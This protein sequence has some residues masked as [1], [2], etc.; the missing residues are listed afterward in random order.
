M[1]IKNLLIAIALI[2]TLLGCSNPSGF[3]VS[4]LKTESR[5]NPLGIDIKTPRLSWIIES[6]K[7]GEK[8]TAYHILVASSKQKL[9]ENIGDLWDTQKV[10]DENSTSV[11]YEGEKLESGTE[12]FWKVKVWNSDDRDSE[13]SHIAK[14]SMGLLNESDWKAEWIGLDKAVGNDNPEQEHRVL[15]ARYLRKEFKTVKPVKRAMAYIV[16]LGVYEMYLNG[17]KVGDHVLSPGLTEFLKRSLYVTYDISDMIRLGENT[18]G[19]ILGNGRFFAPRITKP[20]NTV[21]YGYPKMLAHISLEYEDGSTEI[22]VSDI[23]WKITTNGPI[24]ENNEYDG[25]YYDARKEMPGWSKNGFDDLAWEQAEIVEK[26]SKVI[27]SQMNEPIRV[28]ETIKPVAIF[29]P[30]NGVYIFDMGQNMVGWTKLNVKGGKGTVVKQRFA[31][32]LK[33]DSTL[34]MENLRS[35]QATDTYILKGENNEIFEPRF[36]IHGFRYVELTGYP[37]VPNLST[38][39]GKVV[40]D[41][42]ELVGSFE[43]SNEL[44]NKIYKNAYWGIRGNYR[45]IPVD[46]PQRDERQGWLGDRSAGSKGESYMFDVRNFYKK[47]LVDIFDSQKANGSIP[48]VSPVYWSFYG[49]N[50]TWAG[51]P[52]QIVKMLYD[53]YGDIDAVRNRY[54]P[55]KRWVDYMIKN[56]LEQ[57][58]MPR[59]QYGDWCVPPIDPYRNTLVDNPAR[60]TPGEYIGSVYF[61]HNLRLMQYYAT[62]LNNQSDVKYFGNLADRMKKAINKKFFNPATK[63]YSNNSPT[64]NIL[65][66]AFDLV[67]PE[68]EREVFNNLIKKIEIDNNSH[69]STG[70]IGQQ[71]V[72]QVLTKYGR[73]DLAYTINTKTDFPSFGYMIENGATTIWELWNSNLIGPAM[74]SRNHVMMLGDFITW[75][76]EDLAGIK[77][78]VETTSFKHLIM[79]P[80]LIDGLSFVKASYK[81]V[82]GNI[83]S[84]WKVTNNE[85]EWNLCIPVNTTATIFIPAK[86]K[87]VI[88]ED[89]KVFNY[90][91]SSNENGIIKVDLSAGM[92]HVLSRL[93]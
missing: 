9:K 38:I 83:K 73:A 30:K 69:V 19:V 93:E 78:D 87:P 61:Y 17:K 8:Q 20:T 14:W 68:N 2:V 60:I 13:W 85:F 46:C 84:E 79:K 29:S 64:A 57:D 31:E 71:F 6:G 56:Y 27:S 90:F 92:Y 42:L 86:D 33:E 36:V 80:T 54:V 35:A 44:I 26:P 72:N 24:V 59:D 66:L 4:E 32:I 28:I 22:V 50:V 39:E 3:R 18:I 77:P 53:Q 62:I 1:K 65:A 49:D 58:L 47:W 45:S 5:I 70:V 21:T 74:N 88:R 15:S 52:I 16:G 12:V 67:K 41:D 25:E 81:S 10:E 48:D 76:Y 91:D 89:G 75:L 11:P 23:S 43:C 7:R 63:Q 37:G 82:F 34:Y 40:H 55:M 51:T